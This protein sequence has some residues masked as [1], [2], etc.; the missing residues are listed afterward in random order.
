[1]VND[2]GQATQA[3]VL[4]QTLRIGGRLRA[5]RLARL[6]TLADVAAA[7]GLTK[8]FLSRVERN[9]VTASVAS[10][11]QICSALE[12]SIGDLLEGDVDA[13]LIRK[14]TSPRIYLGGEGMHDFL[15]TP[16]FEQRLQV[17]HSVVAPGGGSGSEPYALPTN[18][19]FVYVLEGTLEIVLD[20][21]V[22]VLEPGDAL[23]FSAQ[24]EHSFRNG[25]GATTTRVL[26]VL[27][28]ALPR[29]SHRHGVDHDQT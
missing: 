2:D 23:T 6:L 24:T 22:I 11:L 20:T 18:V 14:D 26:W 28:P 13:R 16:S 5:A 9:Q 19:E 8:G 29:N 3:A 27:A 1:M 12:L 7:S 25:S 4:E 15:L 21:E 10:L 17:L